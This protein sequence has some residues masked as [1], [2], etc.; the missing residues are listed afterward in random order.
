MI[1]FPDVAPVETGVIGNVEK[2][3][4]RVGRKRSLLYGCSRIFFPAG[5]QSLGYSPA[6]SCRRIAHPCVSACA[7]TVAV[8][9]GNDNSAAAST[10]A[11]SLLGGLMSRAK[12]AT[13]LRVFPRLRLEER[14]ELRRWV[15]ATGA[16]ANVPKPNPST[17]VT[18]P[19]P[20]RTRRPYC[21]T[22]GRRASFDVVGSFLVHRV[23]PRN[24]QRTFPDT[25]AHGT[26]HAQID[27][28]SRSTP[29]RWSP[30][31]DGP[32]DNARVTYLI[33][34]R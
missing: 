31:N 10:P 32:R 34:E 18:G 15:G 26:R 29:N 25:N 22:N 7:S 8:H 19:A 13:V 24:T 27:T 16:P 3:A 2:R 14:A 23:S 9:V 28:R 12:T 1:L 20:D 5:R 30:G 11:C 6:A 33:I 17:T 21:L 4:I